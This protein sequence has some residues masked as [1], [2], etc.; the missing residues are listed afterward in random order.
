MPTPP[1][2]AK[3]IP[4]GTIQRR[5]IGAYVSSVSRPALWELPHADVCRSE[6]GAAASHTLQQHIKKFTARYRA[7]LLAKAATVSTHAGSAAAA[8]GVEGGQRW[9]VLLLMV[10]RTI[11]PA[12]FL[13]DPRV[14]STTA[15]DLTA[16]LTRAHDPEPGWVPVTPLPR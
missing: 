15:D 1:P 5:G 9:R 6:T 3:V 10:T 2:H 16:V 4:G 11:E 7:K 14:P 12:A 13:A 8:C